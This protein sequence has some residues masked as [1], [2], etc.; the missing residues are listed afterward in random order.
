MMPMEFFMGTIMP[1]GFGFAPKG[2]ALASGQTLAISQNQA[3]F[4]LF[5]TQFGGDGRT[6]FALPNLNG[7][8]AIG[9]A[10]S[11]LPI[12]AVGGEEQHTL[13]ISEMPTHHHP[14]NAS[15]TGT[16]TNIP[17]G[18]LPGTASQTVYGAAGS[19]VALGAGPLSNMGGSQAHTNMQ[20]YTVL[21]FAVA[22]TGIFP[23]RS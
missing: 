18:A 6:T 1:A 21:T 19:M 9:T 8:T 2:W 15:T 11:T 20:P 22:L 16:A 3:L 17:D 10:G 23:S 7:R 13:T 12:G 4:V 14:L 5:G